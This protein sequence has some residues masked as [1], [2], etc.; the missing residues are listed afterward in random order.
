MNA[1][2]A[3]MDAL[4]WLQT[5]PDG[6]ANLILTDP[7]YNIGKASWDRIPDY[8]PWLTRIFSE[9]ARASARNA[10]LI[11]FHNDFPQMAALHEAL[12]ASTPWRFQSMVTVAKPLTQKKSWITPKNT[13]RQWFN[14]CEYALVYVKAEVAT[15]GTYEYPPECTAPLR[16]Y[17]RGE[18]KRAGLKI[19]DVKPL[20]LKWGKGGTG[21]VLRHYFGASQ[22]ELPAAHIYKGFFQDFLRQETGIPDLYP[23]PFNDVTG[24]QDTARGLYTSLREAWEAARATHNTD[25]G[26]CNVWQQT[27]QNN[28]ALHPCRK[29]VHILRRLINTHSNPGDL[30]L[31]PFTGSGSTGEACQQTGRRFAGCEISPEYAALANRRFADAAE[32]FSISETQTAPPQP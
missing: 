3:N 1:P 4:A 21:A 24:E 6:A 20:F 10:T 9:A 16:E 7:P 32:L 23:R 29:P 13:L 17:M 2:V 31:D 8:V 25:A 28:A 22:Y 19:S 26:H 15:L 14:I 5:Q 12:Q 11:F 27:T 18:L 30:I